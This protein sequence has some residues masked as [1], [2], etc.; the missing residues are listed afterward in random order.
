MIVSSL[1]AA[2]GL[3]LPPI[4][5]MTGLGNRFLPMLLPILLNGFLSRPSWAILTGAFVPLASGLLT[6]MPPLYPPVVVIMSIEGAALAGA[7]AGF[8]RLGKG[9]V[10]PALTGAILVDRTL[11]VALT[12]LMSGHFGLPA[13]F[14]S[15]AVFIQGLPGVALQLAVI[16]PVLRSIRARKGILFRDGTQSETSILQ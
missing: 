3:T 9:R 8:Y 13:G 1:M 12:W 5:H 7:A 4:F 6:G 16:P 14:V 11:S 15:A 10:W 2:L